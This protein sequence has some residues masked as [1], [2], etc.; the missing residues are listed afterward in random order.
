MKLKIVGL[1]THE[2][3]KRLAYTVM[4]DDLDRGRRMIAQV[5]EAALIDPAAYPLCEGID[6]APQAQADIH[7]EEY[8][9]EALLRVIKEFIGDEANPK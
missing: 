4:F 1:Q 8:D 9:T 5:S 7:Y 3:H 2:D 6:V